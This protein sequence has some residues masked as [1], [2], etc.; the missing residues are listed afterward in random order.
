MQITGA[1][2]DVRLKSRWL[3]P[4]AWGTCGRFTERGAAGSPMLNRLTLVRLVDRV[5]PRIKRRFFSPLLHGLPRCC[6]CTGQCRQLVGDAGRRRAHLN[7]AGNSDVNK[8]P[9]VHHGA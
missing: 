1:Y 6:R 2:A 8:A 4:K 7:N 5:L 9:S 3:P